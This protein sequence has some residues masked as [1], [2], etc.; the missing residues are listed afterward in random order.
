[1]L[2]VSGRQTEGWLDNTSIENFPKTDLRIIDQLW[3][4]SSNGRFGFSVQK[5]IYIEVGGIA[6][7]K[8]DEDVWDKFRHRVGWKVNG[9]SIDYSGVI[10]STTAPVGHL[11]AK[12]CRKMPKDA[13]HSW[14]N[15]VVNRIVVRLS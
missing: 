7:G 3:V 5:K 10:F 12:C 1:M 14:S 11:P 15:R 6:N 13:R 2:K 8:Y 4:E 9:T